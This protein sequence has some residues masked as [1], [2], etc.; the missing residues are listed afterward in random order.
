M[1]AITRQLACRI[2]LLERRRIACVHPE[3]CH[4][5][6][7][8]EVLTFVLDG[9]KKVWIE[10]ADVRSDLY[11][12]KIDESSELFKTSGQVITLLEAL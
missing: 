11:H 1:N 12:V 8:I 9:V 2:T 5:E 6:P 4:R 10:R 3:H 7:F